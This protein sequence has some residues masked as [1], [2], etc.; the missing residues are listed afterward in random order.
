M[1]TNAMGNWVSALIYGHNIK[2]S[3][4]LKRNAMGAIQSEPRNY[5]LGTAIREL[6]RLCKVNRAM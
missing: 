6:A 5:Q 4:K 2:I 3:V 1:Y